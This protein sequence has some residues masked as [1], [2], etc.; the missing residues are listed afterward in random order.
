ML[1][2]FG[3]RLQEGILR[4]CVIVLMMLIALAATEILDFSSFRIL[5]TFFIMLIMFLEVVVLD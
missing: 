2:S 4:Y 5:Y 3:V 1:E